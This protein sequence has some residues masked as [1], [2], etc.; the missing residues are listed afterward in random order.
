MFPIYGQTTNRFKY[1]R[2][3]IIFDY[4]IYNHIMVIQ[5]TPTTRE[6]NPVITI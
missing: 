3:Q 4:N 1:V 5:N 2:Y 6:R